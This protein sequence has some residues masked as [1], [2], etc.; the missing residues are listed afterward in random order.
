MASKTSVVDHTA[1]GRTFS[2]D[3][4]GS[5]E[6]NHL[7]A[8]ES[9]DLDAAALAAQGHDAELE[10]SFSWLGATGL[11]FRYVALIVMRAVAPD[12]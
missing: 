10:R 7:E 8:V 11:A 12:D 9:I 3:D 5:S 1:S 2:K 4:T 6:F